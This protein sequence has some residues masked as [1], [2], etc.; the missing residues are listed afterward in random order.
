MTSTRERTESKQTS[1]DPFA[2]GA[3]S[4]LTSF[5]GKAIMWFLV[6]VWL[7]PTLGLFISS[8][9]PEAAI[10]TSGWW[11]FFTEWDFTLDNY[12]F[13]LFGE[14]SGAPDMASALLIARRACNCLCFV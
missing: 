13:V 10:K 9:R 3:Y 8:F 14:G 5:G 1:S 11:T 2:G 6:I 7:I 12:E 4:W